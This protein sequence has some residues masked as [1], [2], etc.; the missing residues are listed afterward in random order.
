VQ[1]F[2]L[3][4]SDEEIP[5]TAKA[6]CPPVNKIKLSFRVETILNKYKVHAM[7]IY[8]SI[9]RRGYLETSHKSC[10]K[11]HGTLKAAPENTT[12][13]KLPQT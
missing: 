4:P 5:V 7:K 13:Q 8:Q 11:E 2:L 3:L 9:S 6:L 12:H 10:P 1:H